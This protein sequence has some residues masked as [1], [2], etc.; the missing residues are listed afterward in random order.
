MKDHK[1][2]LNIF[3]FPDFHYVF[4][5]KL[6]EFKIIVKI[7]IM[8]DQSSKKNIYNYASAIVLFLAE[9]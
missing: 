9:K 7:I 3:T 6:L 2:H 8:S 5:V 1:R 4:A